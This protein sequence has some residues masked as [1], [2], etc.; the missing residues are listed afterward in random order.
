MEKKSPSEGMHHFTGVPGNQAA[1][2]GKN[3]HSCFSH[4]QGHFRLV[5]FVY[6]VF[7]LSEQRAEMA[8]LQEQNLSPRELKNIAH[9]CRN[10]FIHFWALKCSVKRV[11]VP[12]EE[13][14]RDENEF[15]RNRM[16]LLFITSLISDTAVALSGLKQQHPWEV[17]A[18]ITSW[19]KVLKNYRTVNKF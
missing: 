1:W 8:V 2:Y 18:A 13:E 5:L 14:G 6:L 10:H 3:V 19:W 17:S 16:G 7:I 4:P 12:G 15:H 11:L 9:F